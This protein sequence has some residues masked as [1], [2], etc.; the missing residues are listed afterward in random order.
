M[1]TM[2]ASLRY[3]LDQQHLEVCIETEAGDESVSD[4]YLTVTL[5]TFINPGK[6]GWT[7]DGNGKADLE[8]TFYGELPTIGLQVKVTAG[9]SNYPVHINITGPDNTPYQAHGVTGTTIVLAVPLV[10]VAPV[11]QLAHAAGSAAP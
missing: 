9:S 8:V 7:V 5:P 3:G 6:T 1:N 4:R 11:V 2:H 10:Y